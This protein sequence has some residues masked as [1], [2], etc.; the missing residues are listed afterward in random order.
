MSDQQRFAKIE[1]RI[2]EIEHLL[3]APWKQDATGEGPQHAPSKQSDPTLGHSSSIKQVPSTPAD[4][5]KPKQSWYK[6]LD[7][8][9]TVFELIAIPFAIGYAVVTYGQ[10]RDL[11]ANFKVDQRAWLT[12][13]R[14]ELSEEADSVKEIHVGFWIQ[15]SGKSPAMDVSPK[16]RLLLWQ[17]DPEPTGDVVVATPKLSIGIVAPGTNSPRAD[18]DRWTPTQ[19]AVNSYKQKATRLYVQGRI[20]YSDIFK[21]PHWTDLCAYHVFGTPLDAF[22]MCA[23]GNEIDRN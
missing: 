4:T 17:T 5:S 9:K 10:W 8:W 6:T 16:S 13:A 2:H 3:N 20:E 1:K 18:T 15:N 19:P 14:L 12:V 7:G 22:T 23:R 21:S 11:R